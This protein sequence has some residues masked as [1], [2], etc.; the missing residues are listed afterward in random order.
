MPLGAIVDCPLAGLPVGYEWANGQTLASASTNYPDYFAVNA[1]SGVVP[2]KRGRAAFGKDD[3]GG[4]AALRVTSALSGVD[5]ITLGAV[6]GAQNLTI[7]RAN[8]PP[9]DFMGDGVGNLPLATFGFPNNTDAILYRAS[10]P[11]GN[12]AVS[13]GT[14]YLPVS[15]AP[16]ITMGG[17]IYLNGTAATPATAMQDMPPAQITN[18]IVV[19]E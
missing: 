15:S 3:M 16:A 19:V 4:T 9:V 10:G 14:T 8:L 13:G 17:H 2:D 1:S 18:M 7:G 6:G 11:P 5:G 12:A